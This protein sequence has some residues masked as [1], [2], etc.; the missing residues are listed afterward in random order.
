MRARSVFYDLFPPTTA[1]RLSRQVRR[2]LARERLTAVL[3]RTKKKHAKQA[4]G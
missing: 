4:K 1:R 2:E 3:A